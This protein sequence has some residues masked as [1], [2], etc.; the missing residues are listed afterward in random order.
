MNMSKNTAKRFNPELWWAGG[1]LSLQAWRHLA[2][3]CKVQLDAAVWKLQRPHTQNIHDS[4]APPVI[5]DITQPAI[6]S[7]HGCDDHSRLNEGQTFSVW[8]NSRGWKS[9]VTPWLHLQFLAAQSNSSFFIIIYICTQ[10]Y[11]YS[12][13]RTGLVFIHKPIIPHRKGEIKIMH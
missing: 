4:W 7:I 6:H 9:W 11:I 1:S 5:C 13:F 8:T 10:N 12:E 3:K 2:S